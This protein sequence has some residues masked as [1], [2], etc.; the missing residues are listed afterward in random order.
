M[1]LKLLTPKND[2]EY[3]PPLMFSLTFVGLLVM[4]IPNVASAATRQLNP[5]ESARRQA[6]QLSGAQK[7]SEAWEVL[8]NARVHASPGDTAYWLLYGDQAWERGL[9]SEAVLAYRTAYEAGST[10][11]LAMERLIGQYN[12]SKEPK[13]AIAVG[14]QAYQRIGEARWLLLAMDAASQASLWDELRDL[15]MQAKNDEIKFRG[16]EMYWLLEAHIANHDGQK[17]RARTAYSHALAL[18]PASVPTRAQILWFEIDGGDK[19]QLGEH[20]AQ[21]Q[22]DAQAEPAYWSAYAVALLQL[23][24]VDESLVWFAK[25]V[26]EKPDDYLWQLSYVSAL[27]K[28]GRP[29]QEERLRR[30]IVHRLKDRLAIVHEMQKS[31]GKVVL[32][33]YAS[34]VR[35]FD[36][37]VAGDQVLQDT[38]ERGYTDTDVYGLLVASSLSQ[39]NI[40]SAQ[41]W[42]LRAEADHQK[43]PAY[44]SLAVALAKNDSQ[45]IEQ[46]LLQREEDLSTADRVTALRQLGRNVLALSLTE[47]SLLEAEDES[48][49]LLRQHRDQLRVQLARR[50]EAG[51]ETRNLSD[52]KIERSEVA[53]SFPHDRG[54]TT[55]RLAHNALSSDGSNLALSGLHSENDFSLLTELAISDDPMRFT[56]GR[57]QRADKSLTYGRF[58]WTHALTKRLN[59]R[60]DVLLNGLTEETSALRAIGS[61]DKVSV[62]LSGNLTDL[63][64]ARAEVA[65]QNFNTRKGDALGHGYRVE[66][67][68]GTT[69]FKSIPAW[70]MRV[71]GSSEKNQL[72]D[73]LPAYLTGQALPASQTV[74]SVLS[75]RFST[76]GLGSTLRFGQPDGERRVSGLVDGWFGRQWPANDRAYSLRAA[77]KVPVS[78][79]GQ[80]RAEAFYTNV[81]GGVSSQAN[82][83]IG[84]W[85]RHEF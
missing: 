3:M 68:I 41:H 17:Q 5:V 20:L 85:Y 46:V 69:M 34:M 60:L 11:A 49:E 54:R 45:A 67:E 47:K 82:R 76:L 55:L 29:D 63:T 13:Q 27:S 52:L 70:Q 83:G 84:V 28:A 57:N 40:D 8:R 43:L 48:S 58:E 16:S 7:H 51:Y 56:I 79:A 2:S 53:A 22:G 44:Q 74:E 39:K 14:K 75:P 59:A 80:V 31:D 78:S 66:G 61:K 36:G 19:Q 71:S 6:E 32:L 9:K 42:L 21:W 65:R 10:N 30:D 64:Y 72:V 73:R 15:S 77:L 18:N 24:R 50:I 37:A 23:K 25:Q 4:S 62:G 81:Q 1:R 35:D 12:A 33:A 26:H 38:L